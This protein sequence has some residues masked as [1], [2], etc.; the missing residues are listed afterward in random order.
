MDIENNNNEEEEE[1]KHTV[2]IC[3][4]NNDS[5]VSSF[6]DYLRASF[7]RH[8][9]YEHDD[10]RDI[11]SDLIRVLVVVFSRNYTF[12]LPENLV[13]HLNNKD[14]VVVSVLHGVTVSSVTQQIAVL[15]P[16]S[17]F[18]L[19]SA[20]LPG[21]VQNDDQSESQF[22]EEIA[23]EVFEKLYPTEEIG[24]HRWLVDIESLLCK[25]SWGLR[26]LGIFGESGIGK[27]T[28]ARAVFRRMSGCYDASCYINDFHKEYSE[29]RLG[30]VLSEEY[31]GETP[32][33]KFDLNPSP[34]EP[35][36]RRKRVLISLDDVRNAKDAESFLGGEFGPG[37]LIIIISRYKQVLEQF[38][39]NEIYEVQGL[40]QEDAMK[41]FTRC[42]FGKDVTEQ[43]LLEFSMKEIKC[44]D[45]NPLTIRAQAIKSK[46]ERASLSIHYVWYSCDDLEHNTS[47][48]TIPNEEDDEPQVWYSCYETELPSYEKVVL[49]HLMMRD[50]RHF[51]ESTRHFI[52][53]VKTR[54]TINR[55]Y[56]MCIVVSCV[57]GWLW[58]FF[59]KWESLGFPRQTLIYLVLV[60]GYLCAL[61]IL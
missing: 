11:F 15:E 25:Q 53:L 17:R 59:G 61:L 23:R 60:Y 49:V 28:L 18:L 20:V 52:K 29:K 16:W 31:L 8:G 47:M 4:D 24:I 1:V 56:I 27:T 13:N 7:N 45:G 44:A 37:S 6:I 26:T 40:N 57:F 3:Y 41:L 48:W 36:H 39:V 42:A 10:E 35:S 54:I 33:E 38:G 55:S 46:M 19:E 43:D 34:S 50:F 30:P 58:N 51:I 32:V 2:Y 5:S 22:V 12:S 21:H 14:L 9:I